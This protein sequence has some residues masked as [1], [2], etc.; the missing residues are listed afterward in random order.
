MTFVWKIKLGFSCT[1]LTASAK[2]LSKQTRLASQAV[3]DEDV[4]GICGF[5]QLK[6][7]L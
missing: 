5:D 4:A 2:I 3:S 1:L 7:S 6:V